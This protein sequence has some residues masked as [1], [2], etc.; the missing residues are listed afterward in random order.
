VKGFGRTGGKKD[1]YRGSA[2]VVDFGPK[3]VV[4]TDVRT[5]N[6]A[7]GA[8]GGGLYLYFTDT[9]DMLTG[10]V[11]FLDSAVQ[12]G[13][14]HWMS[15]VQ[16]D[17]DIRFKA[18]PPAPAP[19]A[20]PA[21]EPAGAASA[22]PAPASPTVSNPTTPPG[23]NREHSSAAAISPAGNTPVTYWGGCLPS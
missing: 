13:G 2:C 12:P 5:G 6:N 8:A 21:S 14:K 19:A 15:T 17:V 16:L 22:F 7:Y 3:L 4:A 11:Y 20:G 9:I 1:V 10:P 18:A 23:P